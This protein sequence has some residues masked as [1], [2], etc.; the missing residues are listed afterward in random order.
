[1][2]EGRREEGRREGVKSVTACVHLSI[3]PPH[4]PVNS[5]EHVHIRHIGQNEKRHI[6]VCQMFTGV[7]CQ[8]KM[9]AAHLDGLRALSQ[10]VHLHPAHPHTDDRWEVPPPEKLLGLLQQPLPFSH[11]AL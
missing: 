5:L 9:G 7:G 4:Y 10:L 2:R 1:M 8:A 11:Y 6:N 3:P